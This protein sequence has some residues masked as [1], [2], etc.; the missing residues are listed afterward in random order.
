MGLFNDSSMRASMPALYI[1]MYFIICY[2]LKP[3]NTCKNKTSKAH[4]VLLLIFA[5]IYPM[6]ELYSVVQAGFQ[7]DGSNR[8]SPIGSI[9]ELARHD[10]TVRVDLA[11]N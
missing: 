8:Y 6:Q 5:S 10:G 7:M 11:Y 3:C 1:I 9:N 2:L 4:I